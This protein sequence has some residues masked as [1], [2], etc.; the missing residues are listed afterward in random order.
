MENN[1]IRSMAVPIDNELINMKDRKKNISI[2]IL[3]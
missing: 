3:K 1:F 2:S